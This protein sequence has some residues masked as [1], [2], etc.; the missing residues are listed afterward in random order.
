MMG[1]ILEATL[2]GMGFEVRRFTDA[3][4]AI[5]ALRDSSTACALLVTDLNMPAVSGADLCAAA[6]KVRPDSMRVIVSGDFEDGEPSDA[7]VLDA[8]ALIQKR[9]APEA[10]PELIAVCD[11]IRSC[12]DQRDDTPT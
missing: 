2:A 5:A 1:C 4:L 3:R 10:L 8:H 11:V 9:M 6:S 12:G 7:S